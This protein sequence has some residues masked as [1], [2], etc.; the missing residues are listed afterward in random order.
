[1]FC[2]SCMFGNLKSFLIRSLRFGL[3]LSMN[4]LLINGMESNSNFKSSYNEADKVVEA[5]YELSEDVNNINV[6]GSEFVKNNEDN[7]KMYINGK[8]RELV[9]EVKV[10][11]VDADN[12][13]FYVSLI[14]KNGKIDNGNI[15]IVNGF[16]FI[17]LNIYII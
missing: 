15:F 12:N 8:E 17:F 9:S 4:F 10:N 3:I 16:G 1:M 2:V 6:F 5:T 11:A 13:I 14:C 7:F